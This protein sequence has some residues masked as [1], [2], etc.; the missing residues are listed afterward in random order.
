M[1]NRWIKALKEYNEGQDEWCIPR[2][3]TNEHRE[4]LRIMNRDSEG[5]KV[6]RKLKQTQMQKKE[7]KEREKDILDSVEDHGFFR[8]KPIYIFE[9]AGLDTQSFRSTMN[10]IEEDLEKKNNT[11]KYLSFSMKQLLSFRCMPSDR[12]T[13]SLCNR[14]L[15]LLYRMA[16]L[17]TSLDKRYH[18]FERKKPL[19]W[20]DK[21]YIFTKLTDKEFKKLR[22]KNAHKRKLRQKKE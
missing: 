10:I 21:I 2:K 7:A 4:V 11:E 18:W 9:S 16:R 17:L 13:A 8:E 19:E 14:Q 5:P 22:S 3:N 20:I 1:A 15:K 12:L 6:F